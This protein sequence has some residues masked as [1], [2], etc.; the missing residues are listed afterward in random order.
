MSPCITRCRFECSVE[1]SLVV[2]NMCLQDPRTFVVT[3]PKAFHAGFSHGWNCG[4][5]VNFALDDWFQH[6]REAAARYRRFGRSSVLSLSQLL[7]ICAIMEPTLHDPDIICN[8]LTQTRIEEKAMREKV[9]NY[10][11]QLLISFSTFFPT[12]LHRFF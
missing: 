7:L 8:Q 2:F 9:P 1:L 6:G 11:P 10:F 4:E 12:V 3:F 5:A